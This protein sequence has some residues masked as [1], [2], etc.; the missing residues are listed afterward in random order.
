MSAELLRRAAAKLR[1]YANA[2]TG[3]SWCSLNGGDRLVSFNLAGQEFGYVVD[4]PMSNAANAAYIATMHPPVAVALA[5]L[6]DSEAQA[7]EI[8]GTPRD[9]IVAV[10]R[11]VLREDR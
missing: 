7:W 11:A 5:D 6:L 2:A 1:E 10:A 3:G 9:G 4:E 8:Y